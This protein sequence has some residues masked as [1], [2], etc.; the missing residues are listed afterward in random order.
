MT[1][2]LMNVYGPPR[3]RFVRG[4]GSW[5]IDD[6]GRR[7]VDF[8]AGI[9]VVS[10]GHAHP[11]LSAALAAQAER[12][13]Q[14]SNFFATD[15]QAR[16]L[17]ALAVPLASL[18]DASVFFANSGAEA[19]ETAF[20]LVRRARPG[21]TRVVALEGAFHGR[22]FGALS[23]T[24]QPAK[25][26]PFEPL[27]PG[28]VHVDPADADRIFELVADAETGAIVVEPILGE[29]G[30]RILPPATVG[31]IERARRI[32]RAVVVVDEVQT[33]LG[34]T[35]AWLGAETIGLEPD[36]VTLA[37]GL[38]NGMPVGAVVAR[39]EFADALRPGD[40][41][42]TFGGNPLQMAVVAAVAE[43]LVAID[44]PRLAR[45]RGAQLLEH[46]RA[47]PGIVDME[48]AGLMVGL[49]L[50]APIGD[51]VV[52]QALEEGVV[53]NAPNPRRLRL[54]P[55]LVLGEE[56]LGEGMRRL[57]RALCSVLEREGVA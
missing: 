16:A 34:R 53:V 51:A 40:H 21:R 39:G 46:A 1:L 26:A 42:S 36:V 56:E 27:V 13:W 22:T 43:E 47:L 48:G 25:R 33:G 24:G 4:E 50:A 18:G 38:G 3:R 55:P 2:R 30:V 9:A 14:T 5:L 52:A 54:V 32:S 6:E 8:L 35:G 15:A 44:A 31:A 10:L 23:L 45:E 17:E 37:K 29:V 49:E 20:K 11:R 12:L 41:G 19:I 7:Y 57:R 28:V